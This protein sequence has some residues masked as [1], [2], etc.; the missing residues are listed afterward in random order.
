MK[1]VASLYLPSWSIDRLRRIERRAA[2][3]AEADGR[4]AF[5]AL[6]ADAAA[7]RALHCSVP[8]EGGWR[9]G[10]RWA[11][12]DPGSGLADTRDQVENAVAGLPA[13]RR[14]AQRE[15]GRTSEAAATPFRELSRRTE[16]AEPLFRPGTRG[17]HNEDLQASVEALPAHRRPSLQELSRKTEL[18][19]NPFRPMPP[20]ESGVLRRM[21]R[22]PPV[23]GP[24]EDVVVRRA[25]K[26]PRRSARDGH[27]G[28]A[29]HV[30]PPNL[31]QSLKQLAAMPAVQ[32][33]GEGPHPDNHGKSAPTAPGYGAG[34]FFQTGRTLATMVARVCDD[35]DEA[36]HIPPLVD[37]PP[38]VTVQ[39]SGARVEVAAANE[40][41]RALGIGPGT[42]L[43]M[44]RAQVPG[45]DV[46]EAEPERDAAD[47]AALATLLARRWAPTVTVSDADG[48]FVD[49]TGVAHLH[50]GEARFCRR[51][52]RL[53]AR[54]GITARVAV[55]DTP[56]AAWA[57]ARFGARDAVQIVPPAGQGTALAQ[58]PVAALR[59]E[60][61]ALELLARLGIEAI[62]QLTALPRAPLVR[63]FGRAIADRI[64]QALG[65]L[66]EPFEPIVP[67]T[68][69][70]VEQRFVE[71]IATPEAIEHWLRELMQ[72]LTVALAKAGQGARSVE[73]IA[74]RVDGVPQILRLGFA[75]PT[76]DAAHM[77]RL[78]LRRIEEIE[79]GYGVDGIALIVR[80]ADPL[81]AETLA[82]ALANDTAPDLAPLIDAL[83]NRI[84]ANRLWRV[85][86]VE[87][88]VPERSWTRT[89]PLDPSARE[90][91]ALR[92][93]DVRQLDARAADHPWHPRWPRPVLL[94]R[95][96]E[97][98]DHVL[99]ELPDQPPKRFTWRG[100]THRIV[101]A[102]GPERVAGEW[103][104]RAPE[105]MAVRDYYRVEDETGQRFWLF[106]RGDGM[107]SETGD[108]SWFLH[109]LGS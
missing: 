106:R 1:R 65:Q 32:Y 20:D 17:W 43:T 57:L 83:I 55:A 45:L 25:M 51:L 7:E 66:P 61:P 16:A 49:L 104:R 73:M 3:S 46:R 90:T 108:L 89:A 75:R 8:N 59:L 53:L 11:R 27:G 15:L 13:H 5:D 39:R 10:A 87:S 74:A 62:G 30:A 12:T 99:A 9:P 77:L 78:T 98:I 56:G 24:G 38:L 48:L 54:Y 105:R 102:E 52:L 101:H 35:E 29:G 72:R 97:R 64:D 28:E 37:E 69:V 82:P 68:R 81:G 67:P 6:G 71:P 94:L 40:A 18:G 58:L 60:P 14:P 84:G 22:M 41:A 76:R 93:D 19:D 63:R 2:P 85:A 100:A 107:R 34:R 26:A 103:W 92:A 21:A 79:P 47:L 31:A 42:A 23:L 70:A 86:P 33:P 80:R 95:R 44:A 96:P 50:G 4:A 91:R 88:D 109:G 36:A